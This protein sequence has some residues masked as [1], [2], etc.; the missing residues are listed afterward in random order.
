MTIEAS[1]SSKLAGKKIALCVTGSVAAV[2]APRLARELIRHG[3]KVTAYMTPDA[4]EIIHLNAMQ[5]ATQREVVTKLTGRLEHLQ[6]FDLILVAPATMATMGKLAC[7]IADNAVTALALS[8]RAKVL[9]APAMHLAMYENAIFKENAEKLKKLGYRFLAPKIEEGAA[10]LA[11]VEEIVDA[12]IFQ[13]DKK[14]LANLR[15]L[16]T[17]GPTI[18]YIDPIRMITNK[19]SGK[20]GIALAREAHL[21]GARVTLIYGSGTEPVPAYLNVKRVETSKQ[22]LE[23]VEKEIKSCDVFISAA[24]VSDFSTSQAKSKIDSR[25][26]ALTLKLEPTPKILERVKKQ[27]V[28]KVGFKALY[29]VSEKEL[30][31]AARSS[32]KEYAL[33]LVVAN[34]VAKGIFGGNESEVYILDEKKVTHVQRSDKSR[35]AENI[36]DEVAAKLGR[37]RKR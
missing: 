22:M 37:G 4:C 35:V 34:D 5:F 20:M 18:E 33:N 28:F 9:I 7:G 2:Q 6:D 12:A 13:L 27:K 19:S 15:V 36:L 29:G 21:R 3:A 30:L 1:K 11:G 24:A 23:A 8:S 17:A 14:D 10:K 31:S 25:R 26:G 16:L 32:L